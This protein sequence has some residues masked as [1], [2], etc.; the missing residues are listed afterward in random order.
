[1]RK[2]SYLIK[3]TDRNYFSYQSKFNIPVPLQNHFGR[4]SFKISLKSG[5]YNEC[6]CLS[7][8]LH[9]LL[10]VIFQE[11][12]MGNKKL[13]FEEVKSILKIE[14]DKSVL[15][16]QH[17]ETG[18][19]TTESQVLHSLQHIT[20]EETQFK[21]SIEDERKKVEDKVDREMS[22]ILKSNGF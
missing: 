4:K 2:T 7:N 15:H 18:T 8:R 14:V 3:Q 17:I 12:V 19:G 11:I 20:K 16:I 6:C 9:K 21:R 10:K 22:K 1:M 5:N 13:T